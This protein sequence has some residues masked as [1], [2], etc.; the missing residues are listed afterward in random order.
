MHS[1][2]PNPADDKAAGLA[3][4]GSICFCAATGMGIGVFFQSPVI[5]GLAGGVVGIVFGLLAVPGL[6]RDG[7]N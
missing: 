3:M 1:D 7:H 5:G 4:L 6:L 2:R